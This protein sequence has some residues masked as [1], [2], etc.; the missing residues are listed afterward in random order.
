MAMDQSAWLA[1]VK[2][3][4]I[5]PEM[6]IIDPHHH[7]W[8]YPTSRYML[9]E[10][11]ADIGSGH[12]VVQTVFV[13]CLS[14][15]RP[16]GP[17]EMKPVGETDFVRRVTGPHNSGAGGATRVAAGI[18][19]YADL[20]LGAAVKPV[21]EAHIAAGD[22]A[23]RGIR[24]AASWVADEGINN[25]HTHP[26]QGLLLDS[27]FRE[28]FACLSDYNLSFDAWLY[29]PQ[30]VELADLARAFPETRIIL[31]HVGGILG[32]GSFSGRKDAVF[33]QWK[34][35]ISEL[36]QCENVVVKL[37]GL[38]MKVCGFDWHRQAKPP[39]SESLAEAF[40]PYYLYCIDTFGVD[41]CMFESNFPVDRLSISYPVLWNGFKKLVA[42]FSEDEKNTMFSGTATRVYNL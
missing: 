27:G 39:T 38:G 7:L 4:P 20:T 2:E 17:P 9:E 13:E 33:T 6:P 12:N 25:A 41:R 8:D 40:A 28:G 35:D 21:L 18:V 14:M 11:L 19:G 5:D 30:I 22:G 15:Y 3:E 34:Q 1:Q 31:D 32:I 29:H 16:D 37:G 10:L 26:P 36:A 23:F 24:H 42:D